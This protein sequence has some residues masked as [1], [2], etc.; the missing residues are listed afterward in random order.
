M[1]RQHV[2][3]VAAGVVADGHGAEL[4]ELEGAAAQPDPRLA[5]EHRARRVAL[6]QQRDDGEDRREQDQRG[7]RDATTSK[8]RLQRG[9]RLAG[10]A[11]R[12]ARASP[13]SRRGA[14]ACR[15]ASSGLTR[16]PITYTSAPRARGGGD[17]VEDRLV[18]QGG[19]V[20]NHLTRRRLGLGQRPQQRRLGV[21]AV[22]A[23]VQR[24]AASS[25]GRSRAARGSGSTICE[26]SAPRRRPACRRAAAARRRG[27]ACRAAHRRSDAV[28]DEE[29]AER[30]EHRE[31]RLDDERRLERERR[32]GRDDQRDQPSPLASVSTCSGRET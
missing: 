19:A 8:A 32:E 20:Q 9:S 2:V 10:A 29:D 18:A 15:V 3:P 21:V 26:L 1:S 23:L 14:A 31:P 30:R 7:R 25:P 24:L 12:A 16:R 22:A 13:A 28:G 6:D 4:E 17:E 11:A 27:T 5:V